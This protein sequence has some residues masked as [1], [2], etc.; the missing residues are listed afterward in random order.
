MG[1]WSGASTLATSLMRGLNSQFALT[2]VGLVLL[3]GLLVMAGCA[4]D[5]F[6]LSIDKGSIN[7]RDAKASQSSVLE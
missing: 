2:A 5:K 6:R 7:P 1:V 4:V 3:I